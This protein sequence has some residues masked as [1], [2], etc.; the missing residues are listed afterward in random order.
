MAAKPKTNQY[1]A[2]RQKT[3]KKLCQA[4]ER[5]E[6]GI[7]NNADLQQNGYRL[8]VSD[9]AKEAGIRRNSI[10]TN[11]REFLA[12]LKKAQRRSKNMP[13]TLTTPNDKIAE[14]REIL[15]TIRAEHKTEKQQLVTENASLL[16]RIHRT[17]KELAATKRKLNKL[18]VE[19]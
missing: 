8:N 9:L 18:Q 17:E 7:P 11:H 14:L 16:L 3:K 2:L 1:E 4:L 15:R 12:K 5:L 13:Q 19:N 10:Y 6:T